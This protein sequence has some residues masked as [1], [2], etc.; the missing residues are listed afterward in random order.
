[1]YY[2]FTIMCN[3]KE[4]LSIFHTTDLPGL[5][6]WA[7]HVDELCRVLFFNAIL[8]SWMSIRHLRISLRLDENFS[9]LPVRKF[10]VFVQKQ[11]PANFL[12]Q[13]LNDDKIYFGNAFSSALFVFLGKS[14]DSTYKGE[15]VE[16]LPH[17]PCHRTQGWLSRV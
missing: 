8:D 13:I 12:A 3:T 14:C 4:Y 5:V 11:K 15:Y 10:Q 1:M 7:C 16:A 17:L 9:L 2:A 6:V